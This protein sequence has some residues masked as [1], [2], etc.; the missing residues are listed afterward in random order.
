MTRGLG[1]AKLVMP[2]AG[3]VTRRS[4]GPAGPQHMDSAKKGANIMR[5]L[6]YLPGIILLLIPIMQCIARDKAVKRA[7][8][9]KAA[10]AERRNAEAEAKR[11]EREAAKAARQAER[12]A[13]K[14]IRDAEQQRKQEARIEAARKRAEYAERELAA[15]RAMKELERAERAQTIPQSKPEPKPEPKPQPV[16]KPAKPVPHGNNAFAGQVVAFTGKLPGMTRREAIA[17]V[18]ANG[19]RAYTTM[20]AGTTLLVVG[21]NPGMC[22]M[23]KADEWIAQVRKITAKQFF[24]MLEEP[25][26]M[27]LEEFAALYAA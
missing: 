13:A 14:A 11:Q 9:E 27:E 24:A 10:E 5:Y 18:Q 7:E 20:P 6:L 16:V 8:A 22:K 3:T 21:D 2:V 12:D 4:A 19:G 23:D 26:T 25:I 17:A 1:A 15:K